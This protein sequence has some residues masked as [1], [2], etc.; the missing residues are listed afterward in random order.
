[1]PRKISDRERLDWLSKKVDANDILLRLSESG[2]LT[3]AEY[4]DLPG[5][6][7]LRSNI[8]VAIFQERK[9]NASK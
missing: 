3:L 4:A 1:M 5:N 9:N 8:D 2:Q 6:N 7:S